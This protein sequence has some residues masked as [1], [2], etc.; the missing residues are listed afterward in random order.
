MRPFIVV[1][2]LTFAGAAY[3]QPTV[4]QMSPPSGPPGQRPAA[5]MPAAQAPIGQ[6][7][8]TEMPG[9]Q[10]S[11]GQT[12][13]AA[14]YVMQAGQ[15]DAFEVQSGQLASAK[16]KRADVR[17]FGAKMVKDHTKS[18]QLVMAA[19]TKSGL[20]TASPPL[21]SDQQDKLTQLQGASGEAFDSLY[22]TQQLQ[23]HEEALALH[24]AYAQG[25]D[26]ANL[27]KTAA[28]VVPVVSMH[29]DMLRKG[30]AGHMSH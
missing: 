24:T 12:P 14:D 13:S 15:S 10:T 7:S 3:A 9:G 18:T 19:A 26:D 17:A 28:G 6:M 23:A 5:S 11:A 27:K 25:G 8:G 29:L 1:A 2:A 20:S 4:D 30:G 21:R 16:G 22:A